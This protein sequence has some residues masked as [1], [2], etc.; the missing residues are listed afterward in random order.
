[1]TRY[2]ILPESSSL[3]IEARSSLHPIHGRAEGLEG[4]AEVEIRDGQF[5]L[6]V[7][8]RA[9]LE[10]PV[11]RLRSG[12]ALQDHEMLRRIDARRY[13]TVTAEL[14]GVTPGA[15][16][17]QFRLLTDLTFHGIARRFEVEVAGSVVAGGD[18]LG[19]DGVFELDVRS[20]EVAPPRFLGLQVHPE[21]KI[22][23]QLVLAPAAAE[24]R[25]GEPTAVPP[26]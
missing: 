26:A 12:N 18:R 11:E 10:L 4:F 20:F 7:P 1:M 6:S 14:R 9:R 13:P 2:R 21:V 19:V 22:R 15:Q 5:D 25:P 16:P 23:V 17:G 8:P 3:S 24:A